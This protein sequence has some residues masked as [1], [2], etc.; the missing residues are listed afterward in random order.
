MA[1]NL[2]SIMSTLMSSDALKAIAKTSGID[3]SDVSKVLTS[4]LPE[5]IS[6]ASKQ[7]ASKKTAESFAT[8]LEDHGSKS[9]SNLTSFFKNVDIEDGSKIVSH[10]L[11]TS[12]QTK[13]KSISKSSG[14]DAKTVTT[15]MATAAPLLMSVLGKQ[16]QAQKKKS[17]S[18]TASIA[19]A[20]LSNVDVGGIINSFLKK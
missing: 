11:G 10:L 14:I 9:I 18:T 3:A 16:T 6:G 4:A 19:S 13:A 2:S 5:L 17:E 7:S 1:N 15:I 8:A 20:L 12:S